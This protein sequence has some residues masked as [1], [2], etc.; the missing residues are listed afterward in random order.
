MKIAVLGRGNIGGGLGDRWERAGHE[1]T[2]IGK[3]GGDVSD[4]EVVLVAVPGGAIADAFEAVSGW[5]GKTVIDATNLVGV[6]PPGGHSSN[7][8]FVKSKTNG[9]T[10]KAFNLNFARLFDQID[11]AKSR[12]SNIWSGDEEARGVVEQLIRD[13]GYD[14][15]Y[16]GGMDKTPAQE[17]AIALIL[18]ISGASGPYFYRMAPPDEL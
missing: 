18:A 10:A 3:E 16:A 17:Q 7:A 4:A 5:A 8:E 14:P 9:P 12:P 15:I 2:R 1:V 13:A 11:S 6:Q